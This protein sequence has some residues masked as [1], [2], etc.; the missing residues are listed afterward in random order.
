M[1]LGLREEAAE[2]RETELGLVEAGICLEHLSLH[3]GVANRLPSR[4]SKIGQ[5]GTQR[6]VRIGKRIPSSPL[7]ITR[8]GFVNAGLTA[9]LRPIA[10]VPAT[11]ATPA[12][13]AAALVA[14]ATSSL[15]RDDLVLTVFHLLEP[16][17]APGRRLRQELAEL[18]EADRSLVEGGVQLLHDLLEPVRT[19]HVTPAR[20]LRDGILH[21]LPGITSGTVEFRGLGEA[22]QARVRVVL[23]AILHEDV[24][25]RLLNPDADHV[26]P[27][28]LELQ[29]EARK[30]GVT[31]QQD[32]RADFRPDEDEF[33]AVDRHPDVR[34][35]LL[36]APVGGGEDQIDGRFGERH[37][38]LGVPTPVG[39]GALNADLSLDDVGVEERL[40]LLRQV[41]THP[42]RHIVEV[43]EECGMRRI[44]AC[45]AWATHVGRPRVRNTHGVCLA[46]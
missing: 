39:V 20:H 41:G 7:F 44:W 45:H 37:D 24:G 23:V 6:V 18:R 3:V 46:N 2:L 4:I 14:T 34:R 33:E 36:V 27:V 15:A 28:L 42:H 26:L 38:V 21:E 13:T 32:E 5:G 30:V 8:L 29:H 11:T 9:G 12:R 19:H 31:R 1:L 43:D 35:V 10:A 25:A 22:G 17:Q 40:E 16:D